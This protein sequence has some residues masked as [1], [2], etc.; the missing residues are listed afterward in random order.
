MRPRRKPS[1]SDTQS[2]R[3]RG[4]R[5]PISYVEPGSDPED[6]DS[7]DEFEPESSSSLRRG[8]SAATHITTT[9]TTTTRKRKAG[10]A[11]QPRHSNKRQIRADI[12][13]KETDTKRLVEKKAVDVKFTGKTMPW[14]ILPYH[15]LE[16]IFDYAAYPLIAENFSPNPSIPWLAYIARLCKGFA[17]PALSALYRSPPLFPPAR[18]RQFI[19]QLEQQ[20]ESSYVNYRAKIRRIDLEAVYVLGRKSEGFDPIDLSRLLAL[21]PQLRGVGIHLLSDITRWQ[22]SLTYSRLGKTSYQSGLVEAMDV[23]NIRLQDWTWNSALES[24]DYCLPNYQLLHRSPPFISLRSL[25]FINYDLSK[26]KTE[27]GT[28]ESGE[29]FLGQALKVLPALRNITFKA[30]PL[31]NK[32]LL[33]M[34]PNGLHSLEIT[35][36]PIISFHIEGFLR[37]KGHEIRHLILDHNRYLNL[38]WLSVLAS[39]CPQLEALKMDLIYHNTYAS[40]TD[41]DPKYDYLLS[42]DDLPTWPASLQ[43]LELYHL[44]KWSTTVA[45][46]FFTSLVDSASSLPD[47]RQL[48]IKASLDESGW[49]DRI[50]FRDRWIKR[51]NQVFLRKPPPPN[52]HL[53]SFAAFKAYKARQRKSAGPQNSIKLQ[54]IIVPLKEIQVEDNKD[55]NSDSDKPLARRRHSRRTKSTR[56]YNESVSGEASVRPRKRRRRRQIGSDE[57]SEEDSALED[58]TTGL[59]THP[60]SNDGDDDSE[61]FCIQGMCDVVDV[62]IDNLRPTEEQLHESD[63]LD[64]EVSGDEDWNG[65]DGMPGDGG[66]AW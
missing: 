20:D 65:D 45:E 33:F 30:S 35:D 5:K 61:P 55:S 18:V 40:F 63:F 39:A 64:N 44:R 4:A 13:R 62:M 50:A 43:I 9:P 23:G 56:D 14:Q 57:S 46:L 7:Q 41:S 8:R 16:I 2:S 12:K 19:A 58:D 66:Y 51:L 47:L 49:R 37:T 59:S 52:P 24:G 29:M 22:T 17:E 54:H 1:N 25:T 36:C 60:T 11:R 10:N 28:S 6:D 32:T 27:N 26:L 3:K 38:S 31:L 42:P 53:K 21:T 15:I 34:L 48:N